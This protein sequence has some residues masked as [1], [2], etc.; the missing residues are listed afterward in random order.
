MCVCAITFLSFIQHR[1][2]TD[3][4]IITHYIYRVLMIGCRLF[5]N[6]DESKLNFG[7]SEILL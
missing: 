7:L 1:Q 3:N 6:T 2:R 5:M 4:N